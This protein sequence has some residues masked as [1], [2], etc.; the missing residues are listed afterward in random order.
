MEDGKEEVLIRTSL[1][2]SCV[3]LPWK[4]LT[5]GAFACCE[6]SVTR[7]FPV[8][9]SMKAVTFSARFL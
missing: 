6:T 4:E 1:T 9:T 5:G 2:F 7:K 8:A 3:P